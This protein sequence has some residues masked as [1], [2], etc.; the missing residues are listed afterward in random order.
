MLISSKGNLTDESRNKV[1]HL[2]GH[3]LAQ[4]SWHIKLAISKTK[5]SKFGWFWP[6]NFWVVF[7]FLLLPYSQSPSHLTPCSSVHLSVVVCPWLDTWWISQQSNSIVA[8]LK[9]SRFYTAWS[10]RKLL[11]LACFCFMILLVSLP[12][13]LSNLILIKA[14]SMIFPPTSFLPSLLM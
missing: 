4:A 2:S 5:F 14:C 6:P 12:I 7:Q 1:Y 9:K 10:L 3:H 8:A 13:F 11:Q